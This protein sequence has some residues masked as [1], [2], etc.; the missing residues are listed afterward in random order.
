M[1]NEEGKKVTC[2]YI[3]DIVFD[4][5]EPVV[6]E[7]KSGWIIGNAA[8]GYW[9]SVEYIKGKGWIMKDVTNGGKQGQYWLTLSTEV[10]QKKI[11]E[12]YTKMTIVYANSLDGVDNPNEGNFINTGAKIAP[13]LKGGTYTTEYVKNELKKY[14]FTIEPGYYQSLREISNKIVEKFNLLPISDYSAIF[15]IKT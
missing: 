5:G 14:G 2:G 11:S 8:A 3:A 4:K 12:G 10:I 7:D 6:Q 15:K 9:S 13:T 1:D